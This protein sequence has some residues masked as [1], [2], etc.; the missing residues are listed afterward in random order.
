MNGVSFLVDTNVLVYSYDRSE[1]SKQKRARDV[2]DWL[3]STDRA[4]LSTQI[5]GELFR[6]LSRRLSQPLSPQDAYV[7]LERQARSWRILTVTPEIVLEAARG[8]VQY[9]WAFWDAQVWATAK[10]NHIP[11]VLSED[12]SPGSRIEGVEFVNPFV[13]TILG[14]ERIC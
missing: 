13:G 9:Q 12:F 8:A 7:Q 2:L 4:A 10:M 11:R 3:R 1:H 6:A 5:L 14:E